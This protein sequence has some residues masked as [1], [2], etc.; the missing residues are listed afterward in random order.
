MWDAEK[1]AAYPLTPEQVEKA[2]SVR[3]GLCKA[4]PGV[5]CTDTT[6]KKPNQPLPG[7]RIHHY[8]NEP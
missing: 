1:P 6:A 8:R 4:P 2:L 7:R 3:C 5:D